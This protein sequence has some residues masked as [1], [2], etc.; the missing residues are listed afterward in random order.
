[1]NGLTYRLKQLGEKEAE[2]IEQLFFSVFSQ[3]PWKD[4]WSDKEQLRSYIEE[5]T[6]QK[7][8]LIFGFYEEDVLIGMSM[9]RIKH[10]HTGTEYHIDEFCVSTSKQG[11]GIGSLFMGQIEKAC[12]ELHSNN[13]ELISTLHH[14]LTV[15]SACNRKSTQGMTKTMAFSP[16]L[17]W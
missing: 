2:P 16:R 4:D 8:S 9:G 6:S 12:K 10:W 14:Q 7:N 3:E 5:M 15:H 17:Q 11:R 1:M 13:K